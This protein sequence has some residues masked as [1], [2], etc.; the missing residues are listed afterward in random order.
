MAE[1]LVNIDDTDPSVVYSPPE[2]WTPQFIC[3]D[4]RSADEVGI[5]EE[6]AYNGTW[7]TVQPTFPQ[8]NI[9]LEFAGIEATA[10]FTLFTN[11]HQITNSDLPTENVANIA[12]YVNETRVDP[13][14]L[15]Y[16]HW[17]YPDM[18]Q[19]PFIPGLILM[20]RERLPP[21]R[22]TIRV[23]Y[24]IDVDAGEPQVW[25]AFDRLEYT[26]VP[27][28]VLP[29]PTSPRPPPV[30]SE[31]SSS[32]SSSTGHRPTESNRP[33]TDLEPP[34]NSRDIPMIL[35][36]SVGLSIFS[37]LVLGAFL[38]WFYRR[39]KSRRQPPPPTA[40][41]VHPDSIDA[42]DVP[43]PRYREPRLTQVPTASTTTEF[44]PLNLYGGSSAGDPTLS[45]LHSPGS[46]TTSSPVYYQKSS[47]GPLSSAVPLSASNYSPT[48]SGTDL[49]Y[50]PHT[51]APVSPSTSSGPASQ[52][53]SGKNEKTPLRFLVPSNPSE[54][55]RSSIA[56]RG[57]GRVQGPRSM[58][59]ST[60]MHVPRTRPPSYTSEGYRS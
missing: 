27:G 14:P 20:W 21:W 43:P 49:S 1:R 11:V 57:A 28:A 54:D 15:P 47:L 31:T 8:A 34:S 26:P 36:L 32:A 40:N 37:V 38:F 35:G 53:S 7:T 56:S 46:A 12:F 16:N 10:F 4:C 44:D 13:A 42:E 50:V 45:S 23:E 29:P 33:I 39:R 55:D 51:P 41:Y 3:P 17:W 9:T 30:P 22:H 52:Y 24:T 19:D 48:R 18:P 2:A 6:S 60:S 59:A 25:L 5:V 58:A